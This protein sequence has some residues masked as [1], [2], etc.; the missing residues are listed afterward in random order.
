MEI[1]FVLQTSFAVKA[2]KRGLAVILEILETLAAQIRRNSKKMYKKIFLEK[3]IVLI[4]TKQE[5]GFVFY[6]WREES[7]LKAEIGKWMEVNIKQRFRRL[8]KKI[9]TLP[10]SAAYSKTVISSCLMLARS[11]RKISCAIRTALILVCALKNVSKTAVA[12]KMKKAAVFAVLVSL[13]FQT[14]AVSTFFSIPILSAPFV[15][16]SG[17]DTDNSLC[18]AKTDIVFIV[19]RSESMADSPVESMCKWYKREKVGPS[20]QCVQYSTEGLTKEECENKNYKCPSSV[21]KPV[22]IPSIPRK[23]DA[24]VLSVSSFLDRLMSDD[25]S[26][27]VSFAADASLDKSL[28]SSHSNSKS[29]VSGLT[30]EGKGSNIGGALDKA[31]GELNSDRA[32]AQAAK[33]IILLTDSKANKPNGYGYAEDP[34]DIAYAEQKAQE[35]ADLGYKIFAVG[36]D[37]NVNET[38]LKNIADTTH[39]KYYHANNSNDLAEIY[40]QISEDACQYGSISGCKYLDS[41]NDKV[42]DGSEKTLP[43]WEIVLSG[44]MEASQFTDKDGC[45]TFAGLLAGNYVVSEGSN[46]DKKPYMQTYPNGGIYEITL[47]EGEN[48]TGIDFG[49]ADSSVCKLTDT[50]QECVEPGI[51]EHSFSYNYEYCGESYTEKTADETCACKAVETSRQCVGDGQAEVDYAY[52]F[53][54]C[55]ENYKEIEKD[56]NCS[57][58]ITDSSGKCAKDGLREHNYSY[59]YSYCGEEYTENISDESC[60]C[61]ASESSRQCAGDN[62]AK[63]LYTYN[64][65]FCGED[66]EKTEE[67][68]SCGSEYECSEWQDIECSNNNIM[69]QKRTCVDQYQNSKEEIRE[70]ANESCSCIIEETNRTCVSD[71]SA[72]IDYSWN[73]NYCGEDYS[74]DAADENC[75]CVE[76]ETKGECL[77]ETERLYIFATTLT[78]ANKR[79]RRLEKIRHVK[80]FGM[81]M[82]MEKTHMMKTTMKAMPRKSMTLAPTG[83]MRMVTAL[84]KL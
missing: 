31:I 27:I 79:S 19:D 63:V 72:S 39:A 50:P 45:Y 14:A 10:V 60:E 84:K 40:R 74:S 82:A 44:A 11:F 5:K 15:Y 12:K 68:N 67:D 6:R 21:Y 43:D 20:Q 56:P 34:S 54:F 53:S 28:S 25:Q 42:I 32:S 37:N 35:A 3:Q 51:R 80:M 59:N 76:T 81:E 4:K 38:M 36:L 71:G 17:I 77:S 70:V 26:G 75:N 23:I 66:Y 1:A 29:V 18:S 13:I 33:I 22:Y 52:N 9:S 55:G 48:K 61:L 24:A 47:S 58:K 41:D 46:A 49:N 2:I 83:R 62:Q 64:F 30:A 69:D 57:C 16:S 65:S 8:I 73:Y 78:T 7:R